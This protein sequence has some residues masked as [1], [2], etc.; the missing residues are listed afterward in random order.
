MRPFAAS[1]F[2]SLVLILA[3][4]SCA[5]I[6]TSQSEE[7]YILAAKLTKLTASVESTVRYKHPPADISEAD[8]FFLS[9]RHDPKLLEPFQ[10]YVLRVAWGNRHSIVLVCTKDGQRGLIEDIGCTPELDRHLWMGGSPKPCEFTLSP[11]AFCKD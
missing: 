9:T 3:L 11:E 5:H 6:G 2:V 7:M 1:A 10:D 8:L 4:V